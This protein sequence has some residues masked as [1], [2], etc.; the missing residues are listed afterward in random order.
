MNLSKLIKNSKKDNSLFPNLKVSLLGDSATQL[1]AKSI[2]GYGYE[3]GYGIDLFE[4]DYDQ[5]KL[6]IFNPN[7]ELYV[8]NPEFVIVAESTE[9]IKQDYYNENQDNRINFAEDKFSSI[10]EQVKLLGSLK[11]LKAILYFNLKEDDDSVYGNYANKIESSFLY[12]I[13][14]FNYLVM[15]FA[16]TTNLFHIVD[17]KLLHQRNGDKVAFS[18]QSYV[19]NS[20]V[21]NLDILPLIAK[22]CID[23]IVAQLGIFKKCLIID[24]DNTMWG[25]IIGDDGIDNI[26]IGSLGIGKAFTNFQKWVKELKNRGIILAICSKNF[27]SIAKDVFVNHPDM[28]L[29]LEDISVFVANWDNKA[30]NIKYIQSILNI[31]FDSMVFLDD[32]PFEREIAKKNIPSLTVPELGEDPSEYVD[33]LKTLNLFETASYVK[34]DTKRTLQYQEESKRKKEEI[35]Y[36]DQASFLKSLNMEIKV[37]QFDSFN[38]PRVAQLIQ[39]SNQF[40]LRTVRYTETELKAL[41]KAENYICLALEL[42]DS[43]GEYGIISIV[44]LEKKKDLLFID[45]WVMSCRVLKRGVEEFVFNY[46]LRLANS[47][48]GIK[49]IKG[50]YIPTKKNIF[51]KDLYQDLGFNNESE[52]WVFSDFSSNNKTC[53]IKEII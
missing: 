28:I 3:I 37:A 33:Y 18:N 40:N 29:R 19:N 23:I 36:T 12:Q 14:K 7:S 21:F 10:K 6:Q 53:F 35:K 26:Q 2:I 4:A 1:L 49:K 47:M 46:V 31:G 50:E 39:R 20:M 24:L 44:I 32:N 5:I 41:S 48:D 25:G 11:N 8:H 13:R 16:S 43:F 38:L 9:K 22:N 34:N 52:S 45:T 17:Y 30:D 42:K 27:E 51:V 15:E